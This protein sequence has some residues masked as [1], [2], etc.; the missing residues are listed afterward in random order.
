[1]KRERTLRVPWRLAIEPVTKDRAA[2]GIKMNAELVGAAREGLEFHEAYRVLDRAWWRLSS[3]TG[4]SR[5]SM[6]P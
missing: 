4:L 3:T 5:S 2:H 1:M 6:L